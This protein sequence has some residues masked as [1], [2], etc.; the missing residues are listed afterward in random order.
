MLRIE[1]VDEPP[2]V[3]SVK[4]LMISPVS[5]VN[6]LGQGTELVKGLRS[7]S[8]IGRDKVLG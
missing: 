1:G 8:L 2:R 7:I 3:N 4:P 6:E 5:A